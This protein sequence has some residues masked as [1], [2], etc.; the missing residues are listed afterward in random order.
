[1]WRIIQFLSRFGNLILFLFLELVAFLI[2][3]T[4]NQ[5]QREISQGVFAE[6]SGS[7]NQ[8]QSSIS[9]YFNLSSENSRLM[10]Q[11]AR[12]E[13]QVLQL[14]D[15]IQAYRFRRPTDLD[16]VTLPDS[17]LNDSL[18]L[19]S[20][21]RTST[22]EVPLPD[23]LLPVSGY[24]FL[25]AR[26]INN[27][28]ALNYNYITLDR[29]RRNG[30]QMDMGVISP[31]GIAG[32]VVGVSANFSLVMSVLNK[33]F[34]TSARLLGNNNMGVL[35]WDGDAPGLAKLEFIPQTSEIA[36]GDTVETTGF[37]T[38]FPP[39]YMVGTVDSFDTR[40]QDGF[41]NITVRL[42]TNFRA[43][44]NLFLVRHIYKEEIDSL[45]SKK[46]TQ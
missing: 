40:D 38:V 36:Q 28:V 11:N 12:L 23:S 8:V 37:S 25:A 29:G 2:I 33:K 41:Y 4:V 45:E 19:D 27:S 46:A 14:R 9:G 44:D 10:E 43:L 35:S 1:M 42:A 15:S 3:T 34:R 7:L 26:A 13:Q 18:Y 32:Q 5:P 17:L 22:V 21:R 31:T 16:F 20:L 24:Q 30:V 6:F 39:Y